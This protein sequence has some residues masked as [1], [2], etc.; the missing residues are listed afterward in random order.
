M[1]DEF[2]PT[3]EAGKEA[4]ANGAD[5]DVVREMEQE[6]ELPSGP[7]EG[8]PKHIDNGE[9]GDEGPKKPEEGAGDGTGK[10]T[11]KPSNAGEEDTPGVNREVKSIP[12][13]KAHEMVKKA[14]EEATRKTRDELQAEFQ[15]KLMAAGD[16]PGGA[17]D[18][19]VQ[20]IA[21]EF[22]LKPE[23]IPAFIERIGGVVSKSIKV[24][25]LSDQDRRV[26]DSIA[27]SQKKQAESE[28][29]NK[30]FTDGTTQEALRLASGGKQVTADVIEKVKELAFSS[31]YHTYRLADIIRLEASNLFPKESKSAEGGRGGLG[32]GTPSK[33]IDEMSPDEILNMPDDE[34]D[35]LSTAL[36]GGQSRFTK[37]TVPGARQK[38]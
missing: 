28:G 2:V 3:T 7:E 18:D 37:N 14:T 19:D 10:P 8:S 16:K 13:W 35:A 30:E 27:E 20:K 31:T 5:P 9:G 24:A 29:F 22:G 33:S 15:Q 32:R 38:R 11:N 36:S 25:G 21:D 23:V 1:S 4:L 34:F 12:V 17:T 26:I 6:G